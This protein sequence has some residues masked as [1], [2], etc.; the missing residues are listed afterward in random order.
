MWGVRNMESGV[1]W[2]NRY[3]RSSLPFELIQLPTFIHCRVDTPHGA[4]SR[5]RNLFLPGARLLL[6]TLACSTA[7]VE[8][9]RLL[10]PVA[11]T[12]DCPFRQ[13]R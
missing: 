5:I 6:A 8:L 1:I 10:E 13:V 2:S 7:D 11:D 9:V 3:R 4:G 12:H